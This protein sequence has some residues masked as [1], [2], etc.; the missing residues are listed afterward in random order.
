[1]DYTFWIDANGQRHDLRDMT[2]SYINRCIGQ[3]ALVVDSWKRIKQRDLTPKELER[4]NDPLQK[5]W[6][7]FHG[8]NY[9]ESFKNELNSR[10]EDT[11]QVSKTIG[12]IKEAQEP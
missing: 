5:A 4:V 10:D 11:T 6:F 3:I 2:T 12:K 1:M 7:V 9:L 8:L